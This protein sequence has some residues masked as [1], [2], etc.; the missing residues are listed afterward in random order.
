MMFLLNRIKRELASWVVVYAVM[1]GKPGLISAAM[2]NHEK[3]KK[4]IN[5]YPICVY[6]KTNWSI[7]KRYYTH[8]EAKEAMAGVLVKKKCAWISEREQET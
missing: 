8:Q 2:Y 7:R 3:R 1:R 5:R 4:N 6:S